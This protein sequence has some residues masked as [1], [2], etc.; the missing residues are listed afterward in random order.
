MYVR[1][2]FSKTTKCK[3][4]KTGTMAH[5]PGMS[6][7][8]N[9]VTDVVIQDNSFYIHFLTQQNRIALKRKSTTY[10]LTKKPYLFWA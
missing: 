10:Q 3:N 2:N 7:I 5:H 1:L 4:I 9:D 6:A 8:S